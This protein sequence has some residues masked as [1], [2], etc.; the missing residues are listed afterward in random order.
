MCKEHNW[1]TP[2]SCRAE[3]RGIA[4]L[5]ADTH[6]RIH[7]YI[8]ARAGAHEHKCVHQR[9]RTQAHT[10]SHS[11]GNASACAHIY[12]PRHP[13]TLSARMRPT[14]VSCSQRCQCLPGH[15]ATWQTLPFHESTCWCCA[16][17]RS[18][19]GAVP[20]SQVCAC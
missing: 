10:R 12:T 20:V 5:R 9:A 2:I 14:C 3:L 11:L 6:A 16:W 17:T 4:C 19:A 18:E 15:A 7:T 13:G 8:N 1:G